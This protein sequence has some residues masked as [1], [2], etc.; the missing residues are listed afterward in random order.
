MSKLLK[1]SIKAK[2]GHKKT[3]GGAGG[4]RSIRTFFQVRSELSAA[5]GVGEPKIAKEKS[6][7]MHNVIV[8]Q[9]F[10]DTRR[11]RT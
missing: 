3:A 11:G 1:Q 4:L 2:K 6:G 10:L 9:L 7:K 8:A 5:G